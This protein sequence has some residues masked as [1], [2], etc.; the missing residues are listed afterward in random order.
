METSSNVFG[1]KSWLSVGVT[2]HDKCCPPSDGEGERPGRFPSLTADAERRLHTSTVTRA[3][4]EVVSG[5]FPPVLE[6]CE[7]S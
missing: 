4:G 7:I 3:L 6:A 5:L 2:K 1:S